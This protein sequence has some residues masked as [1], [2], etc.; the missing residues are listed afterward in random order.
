M[1]CG[2]PATGHASWA[3]RA[4]PAP[5]HPALLLAPGMC[6]VATQ[7]FRVRTHPL[8]HRLR[9][10][11]ALFPQT[12]PGPWGSMGGEKGPQGVRGTVPALRLTASPP[13]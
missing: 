6:L 8:A 9:C 2:G 3:P 5:T 1:L 4:H 11:S 12:R 7:P 10:H 13:G